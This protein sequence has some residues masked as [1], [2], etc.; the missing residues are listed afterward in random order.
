MLI[1]L[2]IVIIVLI[3]V[4]PQ[5]SWLVNKTILSYLT[6]YDFFIYSSGLV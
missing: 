5:E 3:I 4:F 1:F 2:I 6:L